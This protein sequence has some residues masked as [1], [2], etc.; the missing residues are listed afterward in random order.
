MGSPYFYLE[1]LIGLVHLIRTSPRA[2]QFSNPALFALDYTLV[3]DATFP[4]QLHQTRAGYEHVL[5][6][7]SDP[8][9][10][11]PIGD[12]AGGTL[13]LSLL[14]HL[15]RDADGDDKDQED[16]ANTTRKKNDHSKHD[17]PGFA[18][19]ISPWVTLLSPENRNTASDYINDESLRQY[20]RQYAG[21]K[22]SLYDAV[23]SPGMCRDEAWWRRAAPSG[24]IAFMFG[25]EE[26]LAPE[27]RRLVG[28]MQH[29]GVD[30]AVRE[31]HGAIHAWPVASLFLSDTGDARLRGLRDIVDMVGAHMDSTFET[32]V[33]TQ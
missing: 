20:G 6:I 21:A 33:A 14:L 26:V 13:I 3:P 24:G 18:V 23:V 28:L 16:V 12:S 4:A 17:R 32:I 25:S 29:A 30:V 15:G 8:S 7:I 10:I 31:D 22:V 1:F 2:P 9:R 5:S 11:I 27:T 19:L